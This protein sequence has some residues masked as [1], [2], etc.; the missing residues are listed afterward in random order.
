M[1]V[2]VVML[3]YMSITMLMVL[4]HNDLLTDE[5]TSFCLSRKP[6]ILKI[7]PNSGDRTRYIVFPPQ[8]K[9]EKKNASNL[10]VKAS[11]KYC[12]EAYPLV[13]RE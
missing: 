10:K 5:Q 7:D 1:S 11:S 2:S 12:F 8:N 4:S 6:K 3:M 13:L 9:C